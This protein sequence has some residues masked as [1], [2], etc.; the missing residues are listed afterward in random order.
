MAQTLERKPTE[1]EID[2]VMGAFDRIS[3]YIN[4]GHVAFD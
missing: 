2:A 3:E 4:P 1:T